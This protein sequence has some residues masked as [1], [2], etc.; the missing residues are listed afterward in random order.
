MKIGLIYIRD[1]ALW[2]KFQ[3]LSDG[4]GPD[5]ETT[6]IHD[7]DELIEANE[8]HDLIVFMHREPGPGR[9]QIVNVKKKCVWVQ[10]WWDLFIK[11][12][13]QDLIP[14]YG[15]LAY[16]M[17][18]VCVKE[19]DSTKAYREHGINAV[20][21]D[22][23]GCPSNYPETTHNPAPA[24]DVMVVG[25]LMHEYSQRH[26]DV[27][28]LVQAGFRVAWAGEGGVTPSGVTHLPWVHP[29]RIPETLSKAAVSLCVDLR[30]D[31]E[32]YWS[33]RLWLSMGS[34]AATLW[35]TTETSIPCVVT[36]NDTE[37]LIARTRELV[38]DYDGRRRLGEQSRHYV[39]N[40]HT[41]HHRCKRLLELVDAI[42]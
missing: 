13:H 32:G 17:D 5:H 29:N 21:F 10:L 19:Q 38:S 16:K 2:P 28:S 41:Y 20:Y 39:L 33:D 3:W 4:F 15:P 24:F 31:V 34:G 9:K 1:D 8:T 25:T 42:R 18:L 22:S 26:Q 6:H 37:T 36:Y 40:N 35:R 12:S 7:L 14:L 30:Q 23:Q 27:Q 11:Q